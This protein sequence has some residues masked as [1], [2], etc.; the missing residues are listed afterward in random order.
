MNVGQAPLSAAEKPY[1]PVLAVV[2]VGLI[3][4]S[5]AQA[6]RDAG[7]VGRVL[8]V[9]RRVETM[10]LAMARGLI[11][12]TVEAAEAAARADL[13]VLATP[14]GALAAMLGEMLPHLRPHTLI[15]DVGSTKAEVIAQARVV[16]GEAIKQFVP[17]HPIAGA[18]RTGPEAAT[19]DLYRGRNVVITPLAENSPED[20]ARVRGAWVAC[21][22]T[23]I[24][25]DGAAHD[26]VLG[27]V[28][29]LPHLLAS[30]Y[31][32]QVARSVD[33]DARFALAG[34]GFRDFTRIAAGSPEMW[35]DIFSHNRD[36]LLA[37]IAAFRDVL[38][39]AERSITIGDADALQ[40]LLTQSCSARRRWRPESS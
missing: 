2:G 14:V 3:G 8:G 4:G 10:Q 26:R 13:I 12:E 35:R 21:G 37:E 15:T 16:M 40:A 39:E 11:D 31:V 5:F 17:G 22:A 9:G 23:V 24:E 25:M 20:I 33:A 6:L 19:A 36:A 30:V 34:T 28:S 32:T 29:H 38:D 27:S 1:F 7:C 18:E